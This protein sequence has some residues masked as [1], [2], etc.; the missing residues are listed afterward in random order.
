MSEGDGG[1][2]PTDPAAILEDDDDRLRDTVVGLFLVAVLA[3]AIPVVTPLPVGY[4]YAATGLVVG[5]AA[6]YL[7]VYRRVQA[8][9]TRELGTLKR[10]IAGLAA[11]F[12]VREVFR[13]FVAI[14]SIDGIVPV[15][16]AAAFVWVAAV[17]AGIAAVVVA[18]PERLVWFVATVFVLNVVIREMIRVSGNELVVPDAARGLA[19]YFGLL[20]PTV[21]VAYLLVYTRVTDGVV[22]RL[23]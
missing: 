1:E 19:V 14:L 4:L 17:A 7:F 8:G 3:S 13:V 15:G 12:L 9:L 2:V 6:I 21:V 20:V 18:D 5:W 22:D 16:E 23:Q 10:L 11:A